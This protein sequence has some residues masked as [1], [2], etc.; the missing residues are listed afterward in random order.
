MPYMLCTF[1]FDDSIINWVKLKL[2]YYTLSLG[3][4]NLLKGDKIEKMYPPP[5]QTTKQLVLQFADDLLTKVPLNGD[6]YFF[7]NLKDVFNISKH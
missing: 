5:P 6:E 4:K 1:M 3:K 2:E 7:N